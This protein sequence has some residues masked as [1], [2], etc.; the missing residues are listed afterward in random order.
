MR[1]SIAVATIL[2]VGGGA[3]AAGAITL[4]AKYYGSDSLFDVTQ[5]A[6]G[7]TPGLGVSLEANYLAGGSGAG[8]SAMGAAS[9]AAALQQTAPM[10]KMLTNGICNNLGGTNGSAAVNASGI[11]IGLD[12]VDV[13]ASIN[14]GSS[15]ACNG[16]S[17]NSATGLAYS[18][19]TS[20]FGGTTTAQNWKWV[21]ALLYGGLDLS[22][23]SVNPDCNST[24]R[25][26]LVNNWSKLFQN[27]CGNGSSVC[28]DTAH[29]VA[30]SSVLWH[31]FRRDDVSGTSDVFSAL[32]NLQALMP[33]NSATSNNGFGASPYCNALNWD[34][35]VQNNGG[36][37]CNDGIHDQ[38]VGPG[39]IPDPLSQCSFTN[40]KSSSLSVPETCGA[41][42]S[43]NHRKPPTGAYGDN[44]ISTTTTAYDVLPTSLQDNDPIRRPC[45][46]TTTGNAFNSGEEVCNVDGNLGVVLAI[47]S[48]EFIPQITAPAGQVQYPT[49]ACNTFEIAKAPRI[50]NCAPFATGVHNGECPNGDVLVAAG[51]VVPVDTVHGSSQCLN[52]KS[53][54]T[55]LTNRTLGSYDGRRHNLHMYDGD[56]NNGT[57]AYVQEPLQNGKPTPLLIDFAGGMGRIHS[58]QTI[59]DT[60]LANPP[61]VGCQMKAPDDQIG[62]LAQADPCSV[63]FAAD[64]FRTWTERPD[65]VNG[66]VCAN[67]VSLGVCSGSLA[68]GFTGSTCPAACLS[69]G[70]PSPALVSDAIRVDQDYP[71]SATVTSLGKQ[72]NE[73][74]I[75]RKLYFNSLIGFNAISSTTADPGATGELALGQFEGVAAN[76]NPIL[77]AVGYFQLQGQPVTGTAPGGAPFTT[78]NA[79]FCEDF[80]EQVV[81]NPTSAT[82]STLAANVNGCAGNGAAALPIAGSVCGEGHQDPY[83]ECDNGLSN[84]TSGNNCSQTCRCAGV[85]SFENIG[86][87]TGWHCQ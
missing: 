34:T 86:D 10:T 49:N 64:G 8:Q 32:L 82:A 26:N 50:F 29:T 59:W 67:L 38:F 22:Q 6:I 76:I 78:F 81:C 70:S 80:D 48:T 41:A 53:K 57:I 33:A 40:F 83:E 74:Q 25:H 69:Q 20:V 9:A 37:F 72:A 18:G 63:G 43:G 77:S 55:V 46:G 31:A 85:T 12:S 39:G 4:P 36:G 60:S 61:N 52:A 75:A 84:G 15:T 68:T 44:P 19:T 79:P 7:S 73:Y 42:G 51:C 66:S 58:I 21:L 45:L 24:A 17:D 2:V 62:C 56:L 65:G 30:G 47:P 1:K 27:G 54:F 23:P 3:S 71:T 13:V 35:N 14:S 87:G 11:V 5:Q 16:T 28:R